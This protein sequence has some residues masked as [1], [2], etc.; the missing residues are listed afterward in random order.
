[1][2]LIIDNFDSFTFNIYR[3]CR[4]LGY[5]TQV[6]RADKINIQEVQSIKPSHIILSPGPGHPKDAQQS[7]EIIKNYYQT[8]PILGVCL[9]HQCIGHVFKANIRHAKKIFHGQTSFIKHD[10]STLFD[11][12]P[13]PLQVTRYHSLVIEKASLSSDFNITAKSQNDHEIMAIFHKDY[14]LFGVQFHPEALLTQ[15]GH[16]LLSNF[17]KI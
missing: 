9:G 10:N 5:Q 13:N 16:Q 15:C 7:C 4:E 17:L 6:I 11:K 8:L 12:L 1:M 3:Y 2:I 14:P